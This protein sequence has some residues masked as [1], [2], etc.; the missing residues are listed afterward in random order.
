MIIRADNYKSET[1]AELIAE[2]ISDNDIIE[3]MRSRA[4]GGDWVEAVA[5][6]IITTDT[7]YEVVAL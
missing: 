7:D 1:V 2:L 5:T 3:L 4:L 6:H